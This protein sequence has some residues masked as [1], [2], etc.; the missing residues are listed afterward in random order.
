[1]IVPRRVPSAIILGLGTMGAAAA[2]ELARRGVRVVGIDRFAPPHTLG[3]HHGGSRIVRDCYFEHPDYV[4]LL[5]RARQGWDRLERD[6]RGVAS[7]ADGPIVHRPGVLYLGPA[8][9]EVVERSFESGCAHGIACERLDARAVRARF[10]QFAVPDGWGALLE[11][12][13]GFVR[14][15]RA[16]A[17]TLAL[18]RRHGAAL[19]LDE[20]VLDWSDTA[21][22]VRVR[23]DRGIH[24]ADTLVI[25]AGAWTPAIAARL[26][27]PLVPQRVVIAW[28]TP[29]D[30]AACAA[31]RM[32]VW[33][34]DRPGAPG[35]YGIPA[36]PDQGDP[37]GMKVAFHA[38]TPCDPDAPR[39]P[40]TADELQA[41][42]DATATHVP[43][44]AGPVTAHATC[45]YTMSPDGHFVIDQVPGCA[46][47]WIACG[48]SGH[49]F[50]FMPVIGEALAD[51]ATAGATRLPIDFL[52]IR[53]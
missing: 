11:P 52:R 53:N 40:P 37:R 22:G 8:G 20:R 25:C 44:A 19:A 5:L 9:S 31:P 35:L 23:T 3:S 13:A 4:P 51:L 42:A 14:P 45:L 48:F 2:L 26:G 39:T 6:A 15:E 32:P 43:G 18:A 7:L 10:P 16:I 34:V 41:L 36:A 30:P 12:G 33:Y 17:A 1:V 49:G 24:E 29:R 38:G 50:K 27:V 47:T 21:S 28:I 46:R